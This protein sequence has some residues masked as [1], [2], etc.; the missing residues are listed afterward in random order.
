[1]KWAWVAALAVVL[2]FGNAQAAEE[3]VLYCTDTDV[4]GFKW[5]NGNVKSTL[6]EQ[7]RFV[8][9]VHE[10][11]DRTIGKNLYKCKSAPRSIFT[12]ADASVAIDPWLFQGNNYTRANLFGD[13]VG[14]DPNI[15]VAYGTCTDF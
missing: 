2:A 9:K 6:F 1:M 10:N 11:G 7:A 4:T 13:T 14:G 12:C 15:W 8:V 5:I 3:K